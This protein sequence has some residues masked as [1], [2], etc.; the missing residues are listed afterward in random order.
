M[1]DLVIVIAII[2]LMLKMLEVFAQSSEPEAHAKTLDI[3]QLAL[4]AIF[5]Q[6]TCRLVISA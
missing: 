4:L 6:D 2:Y 5:H 3:E 1:T